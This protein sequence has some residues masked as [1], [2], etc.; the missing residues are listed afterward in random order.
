MKNS[1]VRVLIEQD[2]DVVKPDEVI[3]SD[4][5]IITYIENEDGLEKIIYGWH[6][7]AYL[8]DQE[9]EKCTKCKNGNTGWIEFID[10]DSTL[11]KKEGNVKVYLCV[12][13]ENKP[14]KIDVKLSDMEIK[15]QD[16]RGK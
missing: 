13:F 8:N 10:K 7:V 9:I 4:Q 15:K 3:T 1:E 14:P 6:I 5:K 16:M 2:L 11:Q 12:S